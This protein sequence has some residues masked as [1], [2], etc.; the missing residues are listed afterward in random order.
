MAARLA[1]ALQAEGVYVNRI[2]LELPARYLDITMWRVNID[3]RAAW[4]EHPHT[5]F[6]DS[7]EEEDEGDREWNDRD[8]GHDSRFELYSQ[9]WIL[10][11]GAYTSTTLQT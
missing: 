5:L 7:E 4:M 9:V 3:E 1:E 10:A 11:S 2:L 6:M 8:S